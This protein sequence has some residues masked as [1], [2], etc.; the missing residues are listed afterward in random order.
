MLALARALAL[1]LG[2]GEEAKPKPPEPAGYHAA[3]LRFDVS[4]IVLGV[5]LG[6]CA[7]DAQSPPPAAWVGTFHP[8][9][10]P[11]SSITGTQQCECRACDPA[12]CCH[13]EQ[14][15]TSAEPGPECNDSYTFSEKC[16]IQVQTCTPRCY[17]HVWRIGKRESCAAS[18]PLVCCE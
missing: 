15:E 17:S 14:T 10:P 13:A 8:P 18:R 3:V 5:G 4:V 12:S 2:R 1:K 6:A 7:A 16:G 9:G 11:G